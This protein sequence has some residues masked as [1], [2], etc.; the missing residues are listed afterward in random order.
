MNL[1]GAVPISTETDR[2]ANSARDFL[3]RLWRI[4]HG[5]SNQRSTYAIVIVLFLRALALIYFIAFA[6]LAVQMLGLFG[7]QGILPIADFI[8]RQREQYDV[9]VGVWLAPTLFWFDTS[10]VF[11]QLVPIAGAMLALALFVFAQRMDFI[12]RV[13]LISLF[14]LYL[15]LVSAGQDFL[16]FQW[17]NLLLEVGLLAI[18]LGDSNAIV[19]LYRWLLFRLMLMSGLVKILS[20]DPNWRNLTALDYH[21]ETQPL[22]NVI[23]FYVHHLPSSVHQFMVAATFFVELVVPFLIFAPRRL[24]FVAAAL[25]TLLNLQIFLTGNYNFFNLVTVILCSMLLDDAALQTILRARLTSH[26]R[27]GVTREPGRLARWISYAFATIVFIVSAFQM[28]TFFRVPTPGIVRLVENVIAPLRSIN[29]Y[30]PFAV[31]TTSRPEIVIEGS[32]DGENWLAYEFPFK[33]G[34]VRRAPPWV[35]PHQPRLDWQMWFAALHSQTGDPRSLLPSLRTN[36]AT[37]FYLQNYGVDAWFVNFIVRLLEGS[38]R[39]LAL[40]EENPFPNAPPRSI[41]ARLYNYHFADVNAPTSTGEWWTREERGL[42]LP[43]LTLGE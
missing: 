9:L 17:D 34:D 1:L 6:S 40:L 42:Y 15:S 25:I 20:G 28:L 2:A 39:V 18:F 19:W 36:P 7:S 41:R 5:P 11:L 43:A 16:A 13:I 24:R 30:G 29:I 21:F 26:L 8:A 3:S 33:P 27:P 32:N 31:M 35:E 14:V 22:P 37:L 10:D 4:V 12:R 23:G 38:P